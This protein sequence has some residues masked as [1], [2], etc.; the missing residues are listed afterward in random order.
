[1][2]NNIDL[3]KEF[4]LIGPVGCGKT[5]LMQ[6]FQNLHYEQFRYQLLSNTRYYSRICTR[7]LP[8]FF[9][10]IRQNVQKSICFD[11]LGVEQSIKHFG[12]ECNTMGEI[13]LS[14]YDFMKYFKELS[15]TPP[16]TSTPTTLKNSTETVSAHAYVKCLMLSLFQATLPTNENTFVGSTNHCNTRQTQFVNLVSLNILK[17]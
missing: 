4:Y 8:M 10:Q 14:R 12:N 11:D 7:W 5:S 9:E 17:S 1:V 3:K 15:P 2:K 6:Y 16:P 13:L